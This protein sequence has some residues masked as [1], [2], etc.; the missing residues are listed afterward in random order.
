MSYEFHFFCLNN[1]LS[2]TININTIDIKP[3]CLEKVFF[4][5]FFCQIIYLFNFKINFKLIIN[6][7][8][9]FTFFY[10]SLVGLGDH[11]TGAEQH[12]DLPG[13]QNE[14]SAAYWIP[15]QE[16]A[17]RAEERSKFQEWIDSRRLCRQHLRKKE[18]LCLYVCDWF[19]SV[20]WESTSV[21]SVNEYDFV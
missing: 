18:G 17:A 16:K 20:A 4:V 14:S 3:V 11:E 7:L 6:I 15:A 9:V 1:I 10:F 13:S 5:L 21:P 12:C 2:A 19:S 8:Y